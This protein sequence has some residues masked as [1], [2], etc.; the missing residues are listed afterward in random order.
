MLTLDAS[1]VRLTSPWF[2]VGTGVLAVVAWVL[3][4]VRWRRHLRVGRT[5]SVLAATVLIV[6]AGAAVANSSGSFYPTLGALT[7]SSG[8]PAPGPGAARTEV[9]TPG[10]VRTVAGPGGTPLTVYLPSAAT[11]PGSA[12][13]RFPVVEWLGP[14]AAGDPLVTEVDRAIAQHRIAPVVVL[15]TGVADAADLRA[16][17]TRSGSGLAVRDDRAGWALAA[18]VGS[19]ACPLAM[20]LARPGAYAAAA[21][22]ACDIGPLRTTDAPPALLA[23]TTAAGGTGGIDRVA[24]PAPAAQVTDYVLRDAADGPGAV[25]G[26]LGEHLP[27][28]LVDRAGA[29]DVPF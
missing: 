25:V 29:D 16:W 22:P 5:I 19:P 15:A 27:G 14:L 9:L 17:A 28:P 21:G 20:A 3:V 18:P 7:G 13:L 11:S 6:L 1:A 24:S 26:W 10:A 4:V 2:V 23:V 8:P 12:G